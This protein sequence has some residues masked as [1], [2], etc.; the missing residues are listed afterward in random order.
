MPACKACGNPVPEGMAFCT[1]CGTALA[2]SD[3]IPGN[4]GEGDFLT[5]E[6]KI[7]LITNPWLVLQ[8]VA[9]P[10]GI[11]LVLGILFSSI[12]GSGEMLLMFLAIGGGLAFLMLV[13]LLILQLVTGGGLLTTFVVSSEGVACHAGSTTRNL[14]R[15]AAGG[16]A[17][18]GS[19][20]G[21][22]AGMLAVSAEDSLLTW[23]EIRYISLFPGV[24]SLVLRSKYL[25]NP[26][27]LYCTEENYARVLSLVKR[28][29]PPESARNLKG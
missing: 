28:F 13:I 24:R 22:G 19:L 3:R 23:P 8:C 12:T 16:S 6:R 26:V 21:T 14:D 2:A 11:G 4:P 5:W 9:I 1:A 10:L 18:L 15:I 17:L 20:S 7:P 29:A 25:I 27:V